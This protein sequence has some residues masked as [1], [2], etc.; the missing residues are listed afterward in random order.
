MILLNFNFILNSIQE[1]IDRKL[2][3]INIKFHRCLCNFFEKFF[4]EFEI[5]GS[6]KSS[7]FFFFFS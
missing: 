2:I 7:K 4:N 6:L 3:L 1:F 5:F